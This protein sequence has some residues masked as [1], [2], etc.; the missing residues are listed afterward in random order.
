MRYGLIAI[1]SLFLIGVDA[2]A[3]ESTRRTVALLSFENKTG[4]PQLDFWRHAPV[5]LLETDLRQVRAVR[6]LAREGIGV[7]RTQMGLESNASMDG[8][9]AR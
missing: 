8:T 7:A 1:A 2:R 4:D 6:L 9:K 3:G 5:R